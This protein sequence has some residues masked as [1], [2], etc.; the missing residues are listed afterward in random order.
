MASPATRR[1]RGVATV[2]VAFDVLA[3]GGRDVRGLPLSQ[4]WPLLVDLVAGLGPP[5]ELVMATSDRS[6]A[7]EW[8][9][10]LAPAGVEGLVCKGW[11]TRYTVRGAGWVKI[12]HADTVDAAVVGLVGSPGRPRALVLRL[13]DGR[14]VVSSPAL[15]SLQA[16]GAG[17]GR[18]GGAGGLRR[19]TVGAG[20][21]RAGGRD[22]ARERPA[23]RRAVRAT[24]H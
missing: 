13:A 7:L 16:G 22:P 18:T 6:E 1:A 15:S 21:R 3:A 14:T 20:G 9:S 4:R 8:M 5:V 2:F 23:W 17:S 24:A 11:Q 19:Y 12:R 10:A